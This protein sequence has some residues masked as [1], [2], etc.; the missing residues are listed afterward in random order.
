M[1]WRKKDRD[2]EG[3]T[4][5]FCSDLHGS[6]TAFRKALNSPS[7]YTERG[8]R[9]DALVLGGDMTGKLIVPVLAENGAFRSYLLGSERRL[10]DEDELAAFVKQCET[11]GVYPHVFDPDEYRVFGDDPA[12]QER[13]FNQLMLDRL[14]EWIRLA[15]ERLGAQDVFV[16]MMP[17]N[18]DIAEVDDLLAESEHVVNADGA[19]VRLPDGREMIGV[20]A[21]NPT[22]FDCPR[23]VPESDLRA[24]LDGLAGRVEDLSRAVFNVHVPPF[25]TGIDEAPLLDDE[26]KPQVG[27]EGVEMA[28][29]GSTAVREAILE[30][31]PL[32]G[33]HGHIH[34]SKGSIEL[35]RTLCINPGS[36]YSDGVLRAALVTL[37]DDRV[38]S[39]MLVSG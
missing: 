32:L 9:V 25:R 33:L 11:L 13:I 10:A 6:T 38:V 18:D 28:P 2:D 36:E 23:D 1:F 5:L 24:Q 20:G 15:D 31:Q 19:V 14:R 26:L 27:P 39:H 35:G 37:R 17:G 30:H 4:I 12:E 29:V 7:Y 3:M 21:S 8:R 22:P 34:E 16:S